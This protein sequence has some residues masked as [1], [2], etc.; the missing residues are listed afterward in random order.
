M[1]F[2]ARFA[3]TFYSMFRAKSQRTPGISSFFFALF[4]PWREIL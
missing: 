3:F 4:A 2:R 1:S